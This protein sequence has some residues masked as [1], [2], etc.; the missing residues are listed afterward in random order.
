MWWCNP[1]DLDSS[2]VISGIVTMGG[3]IIFGFVPL[4][5]YVIYQI[6]GLNNESSQST[7]FIITIYIVL[8]LFT[9]AILGAVK[10]KMADG[11]IMTSSLFVVANGAAV[12]TSYLVSWAVVEIVGIRD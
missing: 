12:V 8:T 2:L 11:K 5:A 9:M 1:P 3:F 7:E 10:G 6:F 4:L